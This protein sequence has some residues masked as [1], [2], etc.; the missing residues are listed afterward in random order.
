MLS[1]ASN[2]DGVTAGWASSSMPSC[3]GLGKSS[4][5]SLAAY[6]WV[7]R[8]AGERDGKGL[9][10]ELLRA[11]VTFL[12]TLAVAGS[13]A[14]ESA[15]SPGQIAVLEPS[16]AAPVAGLQGFIIPAVIAVGVL[17][18]TSIALIAALMVGNRRLRASR[19]AARRLGDR[20]RGILDSTRTGTWEWNV[21]TDEVVFNRRW[22]EMLGYDL[23]ELE[24]VF[25]EIWN[26]LV[27][28]DDLPLTHAALQRHLRGEDEMYDVELRMRHK[29]GHWIW[30]RDRGQVF[31][32][33]ADGKPR[34][35]FGTH[36]DVTERYEA[37]RERNALLHRFEELSRNM[38]GALYQYR[39]CPDGFAH[40]PFASPGLVDIYGCTPE[41][42]A[43]DAKA[44]FASLHPSDAERV[45]DSIARSG[46]E[47]TTWH[48]VY[49]VR[50]PH[51]G[52]LWVEGSAT[53][54]RHEDGSVIWHGYIKDITELHQN[55]ERIRLAAQ[56]FDASQEGIMITDARRTIIDVNRA[57]TGITGYTAQEVKGATPGLLQSGYH[58]STFYDDLNRRLRI[59]GFWRGEIWD[60]R[61]S[62]EV[63]PLL[64]S[65]AAVTD[66]N[67]E[68]QYYVA[69][70]T[71]ISGIKAHEEE[72]QR[73]AHYDALTDIPNRRLLG[74][75]LQQAV[76]LARRTGQTLAV[77]MLDL[78]GFKPVNDRYGHQTGDRL[79]VEIAHRLQGWLRTE[80]TVARLGG[81]EFVLLLCNPEGP[82]PFDRVLDIVRQPIH[83]AEGTV[84]VTASMG[85][86]YLDAANPCDGDQLLRQ[87][88]QALYQAKAMGCNHYKVYEERLAPIA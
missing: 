2:G 19:K 31:S 21:Q 41:Q 5:V 43:V 85:V 58:D 65:I 60:R 29:E 56:V 59:D 81:D 46:Q 14:A 44:A 12:L 50:H 70:F 86:A 38:P 11:C 53:P 3:A 77:C 9:W 47:L 40:F 30:V 54:A 42:A 63:V 39:L 74:D 17:A 72:L 82:A 80:D 15:L 36:V 24:P 8:Q 18:A 84:R 13:C 6:G 88:D 67:G 62:G 32:R 55:R 61:K 48:E 52:E 16:P 10:R 68:V 69:N 27:H 78:D 20:L 66:D 76:A 79:L 64:L 23:A 34:W 75:R 87:A 35:M 71:D 51:L 45:V 73:I 22:A 83:L 1:V 37:A 26:I 49:R 28:P 25:S 33:T 4:E 57:F 7:D